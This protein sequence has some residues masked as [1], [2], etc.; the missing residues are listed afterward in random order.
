MH[1]ENDNGIGRRNMLAVALGEVVAQRRSKRGWSIAE[2]AYRT[3]LHPAILELVESGDVMPHSD[4]LALIAR[5]FG[6]SSE[7]PFLKSA[8]LLADVTAVV[9]G[10]GHV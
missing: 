8:W 4:D 1:I 7:A 2:L 9:E 6:H 5:A 3:R 10:V